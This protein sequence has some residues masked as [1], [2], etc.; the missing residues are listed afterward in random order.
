MTLGAGFLCLLIGCS[1]SRAHDDAGVTADAGAGECTL[2]SFYADR[3]VINPD[4]PVYEDANWSQAEVTEK[5]A[6][7][8]ATD[9]QSYRA[10]KIAYQY[11]DLMQCGFC[12]CGCDRSLGHL[13]AVDCFKDMHGFGCG[14]CQ[15]IALR[16]GDL[17]ALGS[18]LEE[19]Q[20]AL[21]AEYPSH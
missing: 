7:A 16:V 13:S 1:G 10:Y 18:T 2:G 17:I 11:P 21:K 4:D 3:D 12:P 5:F 6:E 19:I 8:K 14:V 20:D 9:A 15:A